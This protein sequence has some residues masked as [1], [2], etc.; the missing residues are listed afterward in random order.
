MTYFLLTSSSV[1]YFKSALTEQAEEWGTHTKILPIKK[2]KGLR[3]SIPKG[4][5]YFYI[6]WEGGGF[7]QIIETNSFPKDFALDTIAG[8]K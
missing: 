7:A 2:G 3:Q 5:D 1:R 6:E 8:K 4:F